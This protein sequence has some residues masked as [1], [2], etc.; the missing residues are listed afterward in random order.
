MP[1]AQKIILVLTVVAVAVAFIVALSVRAAKIAKKL[2]EAIRAGAESMGLSYL[3]KGDREFVKAWS[4]IKPLS[5]S[6]RA[7]NVLFG[8]LPSGLNLTAFLHQYTV[9]TGKSAHVVTHSV[10]ALDTPAWPRVE[11]RRR[12]AV[13]KWFRGLLGSDKP[14]IDAPEGASGFERDWVVDA[15]DP[16]FANQLLTVGVR[17]ALSAG[18][19]VAAWWFV[20]GKLAALHAGAMK[21][22][23]LGAHIELV[24]RVWEAIDESLKWGVPAERGETG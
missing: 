12:N 4:A 10:F 5:K 8:V 19:T 13:A 3:A 21:P 22:E 17:D 9:S 14:D 1:K 23:T 15:E 6:G 20:G 7:T 2:R 24:E 16:L 11:V 18:E